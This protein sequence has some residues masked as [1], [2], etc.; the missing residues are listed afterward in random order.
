MPGALA[1]DNPSGMTRVAEDGTATSGPRTMARQR[2]VHVEDRGALVSVVALAVDCKAHE[3]ARSGPPAIIIR[4]QFVPDQR[5]AA[6]KYQSQPTA[7]LVS[8]ALERRR[9]ELMQ[10][11]HARR[12]QIASCEIA[13]WRSKPDRQ[14]TQTIGV[15]RSWPNTPASSSCAKPPMLNRDK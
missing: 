4:T 7:S 12:G 14:L 6:P 10:P 1:D 9:V 3:V 5:L 13:R 11:C 2:R 15:C 8:A